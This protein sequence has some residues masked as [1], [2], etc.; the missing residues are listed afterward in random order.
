MNTRLLGLHLGR[1]L[2]TG[3]VLAF[4]LTGQSQLVTNTPG[5]R[6][7][8]GTGTNQSYM[9]VVIPLN[10]QKGVS[11]PLMDF[12]IVGTNYFPWNSTA[13]TL[14]HYNATNAASQTG[15]AGRL[16]FNQT[17]AA[18]G[19]RAG[20]SPLYFGQSYTFGI[21]S[22]QPVNYT[23]QALRVLVYRRSDSALMTTTNV[24]IPHWANN[25]TEWGTFLTNGYTKSFTV[26]GMTTTLQFDNP[27]AIWGIDFDGTYHLTHAADASADGY[28][29][30]VEMAGFTD[31][32]YMVL[33]STPLSW[34]D[35]LYT[36]EFEA[37]PAWRSVFV[38]QPHFA[39][40]PMPPSYDGKSIE[41]LLTNA[42]PVTNVVSLPLSPATY[43]NI[44]QSPE[45]RRHP[46][47]DQFV[48]DMRKD[49]IALTAYV[50]NEIE[51]TDAIA[52]N[53]DGSINAASVNLAG[54]NRSA[55][56]TFLTGKGSPAEQCALLVY[57]LRQAGYPAVY[58]YAPEDKLQMLDTR[59]SKMLRL[60][61]KG[62]LDDTGYYWTSNRLVSVNYPWVATYVSNQWVH[63][64]P[65]LKDTE[66]TEGLDLWD[67]MPTNYNTGY[68]WVMDYVRGKTNL[69]SLAAENS[70]AALFPAFVKQTLLQTAPGISV[71]DI[72]ARIIDRRH[73]Y[74]R[75]ADFPRPTYVTNFSYAVESFSDPAIT[76]VSRALTN[77]FDLV[78]IRVYSQANTN[79]QIVTGDLRMMDVLNRK[80]LLRFEKITSTTHRMILS[81]APYR[82]DATGIG[83]FTNDATLLKQQISTNSA[84]T[85]ADENIIVQ[86]TYKRHR[87]L[88]PATQKGFYGMTEGTNVIVSQPIIRKGDL[89]ALCFDLGDTSKKVLQIQAQEYWNM[90]QQ[91][92]LNP[93]LTNSMSPDVYQGTACYLMGMAFYEKC[94]RFREFNS[95]LQKAHVLSIYNFGLSK[96]SAKRAGGVLVNGDIDLVLPQLDMVQSE[97]SIVGNHSLHPD[98]G[99]DPYNQG[100]N[101][102]VLDIA[103]GSAQE[104]E[105]INSYFQQ[106][107]A[108][109]TVRLLQ[110]AESRATNQPGIY[111]LNRLNY[112][113]YGGSNYLGVAL[114][115]ADTNL[116]N[117]ITNTFATA[118]ESNYLQYIVTP[119]NITNNTGTYKGMGA[120]FIQIPKN[121]AALIS[122]N[123]LN[124]G[125]GENLPPG[126]FG[127]GNLLNLQMNVDQNGN[128]SM[129][130]FNP[131]TTYSVSLDNPASFLLQSVVDNANASRY[132]LTGFQSLY[133]DWTGNLLNGVPTS[134]GNGLSLEAQS[135]N[136]G[137]SSDHRTMGQWLADPVSVFTGEFYIDTTD[138]ALPGPMPLKVRRNY[139]S[140]NLANN[141]F[142][143][144][145]KLAYMPFLTVN[146][147]NV[148]YASEADGSVVAYDFVGTN[149][150]LPSLTRNPHLNNFTTSG[151]GSTAN[152]L[153]GKVVQESSGPD[154]FYKLY[155]PDGSLRTFKVQT[156]GFPLNTT[157]PYL[158]RWQDAQGNFY[159]FE[160]GLDST[161]PDYG[162][163]RRIQSSNGNFLGFY[164]DVY[165]HV[166]EA[167]AG[168]GRRLKYG[169]DEFG[170]LVTVTFPD[171]S[172]ISYEYEHKL[173]SVT[174]GSVVTQA[175]Y[176]THLIVK[177]NKPDGRTLANEYDPQRRVTNQWATVGAD[178]N[179]VRNATFVY[180]NNF[181]LAGALTNG[182]SGY[183]LVID[184]FGR[185]NRW[186]YQNSLVRF[187][188]N[189]VGSLTELEYYPDNATPPGY[190]RSLK[191]KRDERGLLSEYQYDL[192]GNVTNT[193]VTG[194]LTGD[195][196][197]TQTATNSA[198]YSTNN[199]LLSVTDTAG[200]RT[201]YSYHPGYPFLPETVVNFAGTTPLSTN[202]MFYENVTNIFVSGTS[203][204]TN[205]SFGLLQRE[206]RAFGSSD[207][208][209]ND[210]VHDGRGF[211][212]Q[213][214]QYTRTSDPTV[215][216]NYLYNARGELIERTDAAGRKYRADFDALGRPQTKEVYE[217]GQ[218]TPLTWDYSYYSANGDLIWT[219]GSRFNPEDYV[220]RDY[221]GEGR[222]I[223]EIR[224]RSRAKA[225]GSGVEAETGDNLY[226]TTFSEFDA[227]GNLTKV[228]NP[229]RNYQLMDYD[230]IGR[231]VRRRSF[232]LNTTLLK[233]EGFS[234]EPGG[235][236]A[237][238][239]NAVGGVTTTLYTSTGRPKMQINPEGTTNQWRY[240]LDGRLAREIIPNGAYWES[241][242][243]DAN[244]KVT[245]D[246]LNGGFA[247]SPRE[248]KAFDRHRN[249]IAL[250]NVDNNVFITTYDGLNRVKSSTGPATTSSSGQQTTTYV[251]DASGQTATT[252]NALGEKTISTFDA[253]GRVLSVEIRNAINTLIRKTTTGYS[254]DGNSATV[255]EGTV[256]TITNVTFT[257]TYGKVVLTQRFPTG[258][259]TERNFNSYDSGGNLLTNTES[260]LQGSTVTTYSTSAFVYDGLNRVKTQIRNNSEVT[261]FTY[262]PA[263]M[264]TNRAMPG[265]LTWVATYDSANRITRE[266]LRGS[267]GGTNRIFTYTY[268]TSG[269]NI[270]LLQAVGDPRGVTFTH[271]Y[272]GFRRLKTKTSTGTAEQ[273]MSSSYLY[274]NQGHLTTL[275][276]TTSG[277]PS[278][279]VARSY[280]GYGQLINEQVYINGLLKREVSQQWN[281]AGRRSQLTSEP[282]FPQGAG[283]GR[284][285]SYT[286]RADGLLSGISLGTGYSFGYDDRGL[287][288]SRSNPF[289]ALTVGARDGMGRILLQT[290]TVG[291]VSQ[292]QETLA[293]RPD[294]RLTNY[295]GARP[296]FNDARTYAYNFNQ[297]NRLTTE[298]MPLLPGQAAS[299]F[300]YEFDFAGT[301]GPGARTQLQMTGGSYL[302]NWAVANNATYIDQW[303]RIIRERENY[304]ARRPSTGTASDV[305]YL[306]STLDGRET[307]N[308]D[309]DSVSDAWRTVLELPY[310]NG[311]SY[312]TH[313]MRGIHP[314]GVVTAAQTNRYANNALDNYTNAYDNLGNYT[315]HHL[316]KV[317]GSAVVNSQTL[318]WDAEGR[319]VKVTNR[320]DVNDG[321]DWTAL[322]DGLGRRLRT[323]YTP[324]IS[325]VL[326][327][328]VTL[329]LDSWYDPQVEFLEIG[330]A[331]NGQRTWKI[332][333]LDISQAFAMQGVGGLEATI[334]EYD[335][336][337]TGL[338]NDYLGNA[339][340]TVTNGVTRFGGRVSSYGPL[341]SQPLPLLSP[342]VSIAEATIWRGKRIDPSGFYWLGTRYYDPNAGRFISPDPSG[343][344]ASI[345]LYAACNG[346]LI[347]YFDPDGRFGKKTLASI[348]MWDPEPFYEGTSLEA[349]YSRFQDQLLLEKYARKQWYDSLTPR[350]QAAYDS[351]LPFVFNLV[352]FSDSLQG[353]DFNAAGRNAEGI[354]AEAIMNALTLGLFKGPSGTPA[355]NVN[356]PQMATQ[357]EFDFV[358]QLGSKPLIGTQLEFQFANQVT[359]SPAQILQNVTDQVNSRLATFPP[360]ANT[361]LTQPEL[362][363]A[364]TKPFLNPM[365]YGN[366][367][368]RLVAQDVAASPQL[369]LMFRHVGGPSNPDFVGF[370][371]NFDI[372][373]PGQVAAHLARPGY[374]SGLNVITYQRPPGWTV[375]PPRVTSPPVTTPP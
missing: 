62:A 238:A 221:D 249:L 250:T 218:S 357:L 335:G 321:F 128:Y 8:R 192:N 323:I 38:D 223:Q 168:D 81:L 310:I 363:A 163:V 346:D 189:A 212:T 215:T 190:P 96:L 120:L 240:K 121:Y 97:V 305:A 102:N 338:I 146:S 159:T 214:I 198:T 29:F 353:G 138:L 139:S 297:V 374:G 194:D 279:S 269:T 296:G 49:P 370:G 328:N 252:L 182:V 5:G 340:A 169:Y 333:G 118:S 327:T 112:L 209:T 52:M 136:Q 326:R 315:A 104:H 316:R 318:T 109:S 334:R 24:T 270:G 124:G 152:L 61:L 98:S 158:T 42:P 107:D 286:Y 330:V 12:Q 213:Q 322:Y 116:W 167:Y 343:H 191:K 324:I 142:G 43:T 119:G 37:R 114:R 69:L 235:K 123:Q 342:N 255:V 283:A 51:L 319:L 130:W 41:E 372:T 54:I 234:Y 22:G 19:S 282:A 151:I 45:L 245:R 173:Q 110:L 262:N 278:T 111:F 2:L 36:V 92:G 141:Q 157:R 375:T 73:S 132:Q 71:E 361:V 9:S 274:D 264:L 211:I 13:G 185:T 308:V 23:N 254:L 237:T 289:R 115:N 175:S 44:D 187:T 199:L 126:T 202:K 352:Q 351:P 30:Q 10:F 27:G 15:T 179:L 356:M 242:Y 86:V 137:G 230:A 253:A 246:L 91:L 304:M 205:V 78:N 236:V 260:S 84:L 272:D 103:N 196:I 311:V 317:S 89:A 100:N 295:I 177:E 263:G 74:L 300:A 276:Q 87:A 18:F 50:H 231:L 193:I 354:A 149:T 59:L 251:F 284:A 293:W 347:N 35:R 3:L 267:S 313:I 7:L 144:G 48:S 26:Y 76:N 32:G 75:W 256:N 162:E 101:L 222:Q 358:N 239:T 266:E 46:I 290:N 117:T 39:G 332:H 301:N 369:N 233:A 355:P 106:N 329:T 184:V 247:L 53:D 82:S 208:A 186:D 90:E 21:Y 312:S 64:F 197:L 195:G 93:S 365:A 325:G 153:R 229:R 216:N 273:N 336:Y 243:D 226:A 362:I 33:N 145:W 244:R 166:T 206:I 77:A 143:F 210:W 188:T 99:D 20:G 280:D 80:F 40:K 134:F 345:D 94:G 203:T 135:G 171:A 292:L 225:D 298:T 314:T 150:W 28:V 302:N 258:S 67:L 180:S 155:S 95:H 31:K 165:G 140:Q 200:N 320:D 66:I 156:F 219:D 227:F 303:K 348:M 4:S 148:I 248:T 299:T 174:N 129:N 271:Y 220:W 83:T 178:L 65:W 133:G 257:D 181:T 113:N 72:G 154:T 217:P 14:Y 288:T 337:A 339:V 204:F 228:T 161:Q 57:L 16:P 47:L 281:A 291:G 88:T 170:D 261:A 285:L 349:D 160:Y 360:L 56:T 79:R 17:V 58:A 172:Q 275:S 294:G 306:T 350:Q 70:P 183:T 60:Q 364:Q 341:P 373:T 366:A 68:K 277:Q 344:A 108:I 105:I 232:D 11:L 176:S 127:L 34:W 224:W 164:F 207:A 125:S 122:P 241:T 265:P 55:L 259:I 359:A 307:K 268:Y 1:T 201:F 368:E 367:V 85:S 6:Y 371:L 287:L 63:V 25:P 131:A 147:S 309:Y 331:I